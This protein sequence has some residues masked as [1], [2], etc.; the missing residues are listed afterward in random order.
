MPTRFH[1]ILIVL[2]SSLM[3]GAFALAADPASQ[4]AKQPA[5]KMN[6]DTCLACHG[7][8]DKLIEA[9]VPFK[10][11][12]NETVVPHRY[13]PHAEKKDIPECTECHTPH[14]V[15]LEDVSTVVI[16]K[17]LKWCY[18][19]CHHQNNFQACSGCH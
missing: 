18:A 13:V 11:P 9:S 15:P 14:K 2:A 4:E 17:D 12:E 19:T 7:P 5:N 16:P 10:T 3:L 6:K 1:V 8:Y